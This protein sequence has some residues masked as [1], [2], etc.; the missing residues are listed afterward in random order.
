MV[1]VINVCGF[2]TSLVTAVLLIENYFF[3]DFKNIFIII[4]YNLLSHYIT[5]RNSL[6]NFIFINIMHTV[7]NVFMQTSIIKKY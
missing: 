1:H 6:F 3:S 7:Q 5:T 2:L 4:T